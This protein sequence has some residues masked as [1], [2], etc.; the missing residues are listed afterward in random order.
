MHLLKFAVLSYIQKRGIE[1]LIHVF[2][3]IVNPH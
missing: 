1:E 3:N 2:R